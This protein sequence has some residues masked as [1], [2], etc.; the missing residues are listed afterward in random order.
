MIVANINSFFCN[1]KQFH[2]LLFCQSLLHV[3]I[4]ISLRYLTIFV[5]LRHQM[6]S[7]MRKKQQI[8]VLMVCLFAWGTGWAQHIKFS[9]GPNI[10]I[11]IRH[12]KDT[13][14]TAYANLGIMTNVYNVRGLDVN[15]LSSFVQNNMN[16]VQL[17]G[18]G[19]IVARNANGVQLGV[20]ANGIGGN[21]N[22]LIVSGLTNGV[23]KNMNGVAIAGLCNLSGDYQNGL[24]IAGFTN[25]AAKRLNGMQL[26]TFI[27]VCGDDGRG[28]QL[29]L[30]NVAY[31]IKGAQIGL[32]SNIVTHRLNGFQYSAI[33]NVAAT[34][35]RALQ[36]AA[37][38]N[39][40]IDQMN[41]AQLAV[42]NYANRLKGAQIGIINICSETTKGYQIGVVN[43]SR[44]STAHKIG[45]INISPRTR[46]QFLLYGSNTSKLNMALRFQNKITYSM[47]GVG[48]HYLGLSKEFSGC[49]FYRTGLFKQL[50]RRWQLSADLGYY[51]IEN[52]DNKDV[53][54]PERMYS[55]QC[56]GNVEF[57]LTKYTTIFASGGYS[58]TRYYDKNKKYQYK[59]VVD[60]GFAFN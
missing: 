44:D 32:F 29:A 5:S 52:F 45:L 43:F 41:G 22:G 54:T 16:G 31:D 10:A 26:S 18:I 8:I 33:S 17:S 42:Y 30:N 2:I 7:N 39:I 50:S 49:L 12:T 53:N 24:A 25:I 11:G 40:C 14:K 58:W 19:N 47:F 15:V 21:S 9:K 34:T 60:V 28:M 51:H 55:L 46:I 59:P 3:F 56:R 37:L 13:V 6:N 35:H 20:L 1:T 27:N 38:S 57:R 36:W 48:T 4:A 23:R